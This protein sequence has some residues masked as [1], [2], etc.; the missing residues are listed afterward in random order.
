M[1]Y[2]VPA[3]HHL[4]MLIHQHLAMHPKMGSSQRGGPSMH[5]AWVPGVYAAGLGQVGNDPREALGEASRKNGDSRCRDEATAGGAQAC[6]I[7]HQ[8]KDW[9]GG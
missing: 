4:P 5:A 2:D 6:P 1:N 9:D 3:Y 7:E 8:R